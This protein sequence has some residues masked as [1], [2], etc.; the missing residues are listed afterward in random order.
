[1]EANEILK[2]KV[3][4][5]L[6]LHNIQN[7]LYNHIDTLIKSGAVD[8]ETIEKNGE[9]ANIIAN[10][11]YSIEM[12]RQSKVFRYNSGKG[13]AERKNIEIFI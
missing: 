6:S 8:I 9:Y 1:M 4:T 11:I 13:K 12:G 7:R 3:N 10:C 2:E 5:I